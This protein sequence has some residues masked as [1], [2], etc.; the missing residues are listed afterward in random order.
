MT[1]KA[2]GLEQINNSTTTQ[3][4][5]QA[6]LIVADGSC[7]KIREL[8]AEA[9]VPVL[10]LDGEQEPLAA[11]SDALSDRREHG[12]PVKAL[13]WVSHGSPGVLRVGEKKVNRAALLAASNQ[14]IDW[15][16]DE[17]AL[18]ACDYGADNSAL[19]LWEE[20]LGTSVYSSSG[21]LG[22]DTDGQ[23]HWTLHS[24]GHSN[25]INWPL[26]FGDSDTWAYQL[27]TVSY[28]TFSEGPQASAPLTSSEQITAVGYAASQ[29]SIDTAYVKPTFDAIGNLSYTTYTDD[30]SFLDSEIDADLVY[31]IFPKSVPTTSQ[32]DNLKQFVEGGGTLLISGEW[33][34]SFD[35]INSNASEILNYVGSSIAVKEGVGSIRDNDLNA[36][37]PDGTTDIVEIGNYD[38][39]SGLSTVQT[40]TF[41]ALEI[42]DES[43]EAILVTSENATN[44]IVMAR[45]TVGS[46]NTIVFA[47]VNMFDADNNDLFSNIIIQSKRNIEEVVAAA[48]AAAAEAE[49]AAKA[50]EAA[51]NTEI[52]YL[53]GSDKATNISLV[54]T[55][56]AINSKARA[57]LSDSG[58]TLQ[59]DSLNFE[60]AIDESI[61]RTTFNLALSS[62]NFENGAITTSEGKRD[63]S[64]KLLYYSVDDE[65]EVSALSFD[66]LVNAGARFYDLDGDGL[67]DY[68]SL[69]LIDG[70]FGDKDGTKNGVIVDP[71][72]AA[73]VALDPV[74][75]A[76]D[77]PFNLLTIADPNNAAPAAL[78][79]SATITGR[80]KAVHQ[81]G[82]IVLDANEV[83]SAKTILGDL[84]QLKER[85]TIVFSS[86]EADDVVIPDNYTFKRDLL[87]RN[88]QS[89]RFFSLADTTLDTLKS[90]KDSRLSFLDSTVNSDGSV[91]FA[92]SA[93]LSFNL[94]LN[95]NDQGLNALVAQEQGI[96]PVLDGTAFSNGE[97]LRGVWAQAREATLDALTGF[98]RV[99]DPTGVV[100]AADGS[101]IAPGAAGYTEAALR[102]DNLY[103]GDTF[104][105]SLAN[106]KTEEASLEMGDLGGYLAPYAKVQSNTFF[107]FA[108]AN[109]DGISHFRVL[110]NNV[111]GLEDQFGGGDRDFDDHI[112][113]FQFDSVT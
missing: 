26:N 20:L 42:D 47:D 99:V 49:A 5:R 109:A 74:I 111:F 6:T 2:C 25:T 110:G 98:Y 1:L 7:P 87:V 35:D 32:L 85:A 102:A 69:T 40:R 36:T 9:L 96:A 72:T 22:L 78:N 94:A 57:V 107:A 45:E 52:S 83:A 93:G 14:L 73:S 27:A 30:Y 12:Q 53:S 82:Y 16:L 68:L 29:Y 33:S 91:S 105:F 71:S 60:A 81:I 103:G 101:L 46:G 15:Q 100:M 10:W 24:K 112:I 70:G 54:T 21:I 48:A 50:A 106:N 75:Q 67:A 23:K 17:L 37:P 13:H 34:P 61:P 11:I 8:L 39:T 51:P 76:N 41:G 38:I 66:P 89:L 79:L 77:G 108:K 63:T 4:Q 80:S 59:T 58:I 31:I 18:W 56:D 3:G 92:A 44:N 19:S 95:A 97:S 90:V 104:T 65:G 64:Q 62:L 84:D 43:A 113:G 88:G 28:A 55:V 86:L